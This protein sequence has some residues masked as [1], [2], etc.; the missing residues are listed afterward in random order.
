MQVLAIAV[1]F[2]PERLVPAFRGPAEIYA[3]A[4]LTRGTGPVAP[5]RDAS[6]AGR[7]NPADANRR[8]NDV[9]FKKTS[10]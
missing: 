6:G 8:P 1:R 5:G 7:R 4:G 10:F 9:P 3:R 2:G